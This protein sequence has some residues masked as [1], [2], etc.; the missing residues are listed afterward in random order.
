MTRAELY[1]QLDAIRADPSQRAQREN[2]IWKEA[3]SQRAIL[4]SDLTG[5][6]RVTREKGIVHFLS[7]FR[8]FSCQV[9]PLLDRHGAV[10]KKIVADN[11]MAVFPDVASAAAVADVLRNLTIQEVTC[12]VGIG[13]GKILLLEDDAFGNEVN[14]AYKL[15]EDVAQTRQVLL[16]EPA[17]AQFD[18]N[19]LEGPFSIEI[20][21]VCLTHFRLKE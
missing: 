19:R 13:Y 4:V 8:E 2:L 5:F 11:I 7:V 14:L 16:T 3:S 10:L 17:A 21:R 15:G 9:E 12:C 6:T 20:S 1:A 18:P